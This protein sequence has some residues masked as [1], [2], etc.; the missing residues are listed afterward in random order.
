MQRVNVPVDEI[1][2]IVKQLSLCKIELIYIEK[3]ILQI[4]V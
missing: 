1:V 3:R 2:L 4:D